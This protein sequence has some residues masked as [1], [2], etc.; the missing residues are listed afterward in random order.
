MGNVRVEVNQMPAGEDVSRLS[1]SR[2]FRCLYYHN[3]L[4]EPQELL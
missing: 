1:P 4:L 2:F 3:W